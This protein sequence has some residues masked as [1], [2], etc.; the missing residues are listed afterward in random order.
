MLNAKGKSRRAR[1]TITR[2]ETNNH[3]IYYG[4][5]Y[6]GSTSKIHDNKD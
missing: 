6:S 1:S 5:G 2:I 4:F 3:E